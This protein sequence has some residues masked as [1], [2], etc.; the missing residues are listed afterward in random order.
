LGLEELFIK[1]EI[2]RQRIQVDF[3][4][5]SMDSLLQLIDDFL[6]LKNSGSGDQKQIIF[7][8]E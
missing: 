8:M 3:Q 2:M 5:C 1:I 7:E 6:K 4:S